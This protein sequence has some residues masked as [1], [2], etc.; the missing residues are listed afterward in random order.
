MY[1]VIKH[2][3]L[4]RRFPEVADQ[5]LL[6]PRYEPPQFSM[7]LCLRMFIRGPGSKNMLCTDVSLLSPR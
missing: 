5:I 2:M 1:S 4:T 6:V 7:N 3:H